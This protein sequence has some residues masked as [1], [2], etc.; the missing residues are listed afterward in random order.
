[1]SQPASDTAFRI[2]ER[3]GPAGRLVLRAE[4]GERVH[5]LVISGYRGPALPERI[6]RAQVIEA[7]AAAGPR[8][9]W[10]L[11]AGPSD[12]EFE[13][14]AVDRIEECPALFAALHR[15]FA[16]SG[17]DRLGARALLGLLRLPGG[18]RLMRLWHARRGR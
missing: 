7:D 2:I 18:A 3:D 5:Y 15:P 9:T 8:Q 17:A 4:S 1:M 14:R 11:A 13:A 10:R 12:L 6:E 16:L